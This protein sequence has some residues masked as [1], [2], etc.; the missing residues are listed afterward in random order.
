MNWHQIVEEVTPHIVK[1][2][3]QDS[4]GTGFLTLY[5][6]NKTLCG[7]ATAMHVVAQAKEQFIPSLQPSP[8]QGT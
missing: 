7:V 8:P 2:E 5:N 6:E 4:Y 1:I 3:T